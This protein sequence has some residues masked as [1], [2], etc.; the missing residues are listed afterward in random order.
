MKLRFTPLEARQLGGLRGFG[1][2][3]FITNEPEAAAEVAGDYLRE[4]VAAGQG[5][6]IR[7]GDA[8]R[9]TGR[10]G[11][12]ASC[13]DTDFLPQEPSSPNPNKEKRG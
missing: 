4:P 13:S 10:F 11:G 9:E 2:S 1:F 12:D 6:I 7:E 8:P 5:Q 3:V